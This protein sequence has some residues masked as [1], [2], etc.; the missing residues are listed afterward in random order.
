MTKINL[1]W[2]IRPD[3]LFETQW[4]RELLSVGNL[5]YTEIFELDPA[6]AQI[7][8]KSV[9]VFNHAIDYETYFAKYETAQIPFG[10]I[11]L[12][13]ETLGDTTRFYGQ[14][15]CKF[16]FRNYHHP[17]VSATYRHVVTFGLGYKSGFSTIAATPKLP[18]SRY[19]HWSFAGNIHTPERM[20]SIT[21]LLGIVPHRLHT[22]QEGF[23]ASSGLNTQEYRRLM[24]ESKFV[25]CP[26]GQGNIDSFR[27]YEALE[28]G[29][30]P[31]VLAATA[32]QPYQPSYW[33]TMFPW[34][35]GT[36]I[37]MLIHRNWED[38]AKTMCEIIQTKD[39]YE[40]LH[41]QVVSFWE[42]AKKIWGNVLEAYCLM[43]D[44]VIQD[45]LS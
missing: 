2:I 34:M 13:D 8:P 19:Y 6:Q 26:I 39:T 31:V 4:I 22:T 38:A 12:S 24:D 27:V 7:H 33:H 25:I 5:E 3:G 44:S 42:N 23:N 29:A 11:H 45:D 9:V 16:V 18:T 43:L 37:P 17:I 20:A 30:I 28:A 36:T 40:D 15:T 32:V 10:A 1:V 14:K 21:P 41:K 35:R